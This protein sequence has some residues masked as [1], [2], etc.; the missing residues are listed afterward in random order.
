MQLS[1]QSSEDLD[2]QGS[3]RSRLA[4][5]EV[6]CAAHIL[7][8]YLVRYLSCQQIWPRGEIPFATSAMIV[9]LHWALQLCFV[10][11]RWSLALKGF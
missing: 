11:S 8:K 2:P 9:N 6:S 3:M 5:L 10:S 1:V 4:A 7:G